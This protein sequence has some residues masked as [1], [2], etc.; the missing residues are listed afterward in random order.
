MK[1][2]VK[3]LC[4]MC[5]FFCSSCSKEDELIEIGIAQIVEH[6]S[7]N[8]IREAIVDELSNLG[9]VDQEN[10]QIDYK[11]ASNDMN[12]LTSIMQTFVGNQVDVICAIA[13]PTAMAAAPYANQVPV[14]FSAVSDPIQAGL[15][16]D[17]NRPSHNITG[18]SDEI[19]VDQILDL[20]VSLLPDIQTLGYIYNTSEA[21]SVSHLAKVQDYCEKNQID[22][23]EMSVTNVS[24]VLSVA[25][26]LAQKCDAIFAPN[27]NTVANAMDAL[28]KVSS[29]L[30]IP[31]FVGADSMVVDGG[32]ATVGITYEELGKETARMIAS[33]LEGKKIEE[34]PVKIFNTDLMVFLNETKAQELGIQ[35]PSSL[36][37]SETTIIVK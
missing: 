34:L 6:P 36:L 1:K 7:L 2:L 15:L 13:T 16:E 31:V 12:T 22:L 28:N 24:E 11:N 5:L 26:A 8:T 9:Y 35:L 10:I 32:L 18:T 29:D 25:T 19:Q 33:V 30:S 3:L 27:D 17:L 14:I 20:A 37:E 21:N 4:V 23:V